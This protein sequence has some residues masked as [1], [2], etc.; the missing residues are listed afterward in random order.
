MTHSVK[1]CVLDLCVFEKDGTARMSL[2]KS[3]TPL[4][5]PAWQNRY[6]ILQKE[7]SRVFERYKTLMDDGQSADLL[8]LT[9][10]LASNS[11]LYKGKV[12][13]GGKAIS[14]DCCRTARLSATRSVALLQAFSTY[15]SRPAFETDVGKSLS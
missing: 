11:R 13:V 9:I 12:D 15:L 5:V 3:C 4:A 14:Y 8:D 7:A 2:T 10:P 1:L 6:T